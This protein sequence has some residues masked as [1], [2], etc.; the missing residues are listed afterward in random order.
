MYDICVEGALYTDRAL[1]ID[2]ALYIDSVP[3]TDRALYI[4]RALYIDRVLYIGALQRQSALHSVGT[5]KTSWMK[6]TCVCQLPRHGR[7][8]RMGSRPK[9]T[10]LSPFVVGYIFSVRHSCFGEYLFLINY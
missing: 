7:V 10:R 2:K 8:E 3:Y 9:E 1:Y 4:G 6:S 5:K